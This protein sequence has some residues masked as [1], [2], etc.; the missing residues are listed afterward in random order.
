MGKGEGPG[1]KTSGLTPLWEVELIWLRASTWW[2]LFTPPRPSRCPLFHS[3]VAPLLA[4]EDQRMLEYVGGTH[5][6]L[7]FNRWMVQRDSAV[8]DPAPESLKRR[9]VSGA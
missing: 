6:G 3:K 7:A 1:N 9:N 5:C 2:A 4:E 8:V